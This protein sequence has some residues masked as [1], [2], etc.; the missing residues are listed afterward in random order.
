MNKLACGL[1]LPCALLWGLLSAPAPTQ[2]ALE[3]FGVKVQ[4]NDELVDFPDAQP[5][6]DD[7]HRLQVPVRLVG[8]KLGFR[9]DWEMSGASVKVTLSKDR[10]L[11]QLAT[12]Q[13]T[14]TVNGRKQTLDTH[15]VLK[16]GRVYVPLRFISEAAG[17]GVQWDQRNRIAILIADGKYHAPAWYAPDPAI[18][19]ASAYTADHAENG[20]YGAVDFFGN[21]L[22]LGT[23]AV[24]PSVIP[25]GST[26][27]I[28]GYSFDGLPA[29]GMT[30]KA[31]DTGGG[32]KGNRLDIFVPGA[33][34][35]IRSFGLQKVKVYV[36]HE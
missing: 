31:T 23:V 24:D 20:G 1:F 28:E 26:L 30:A 2:A 7:Q 27:Y 6:V 10:H 29:G 34:S 11:I 17:I 8:E 32:I 18:F 33:K 36:L 22:E 9:V 25:L 15:P 19:E 13:Q 5:F 14:A 3:P 16:E 21:P 35:L 4:I 12:S